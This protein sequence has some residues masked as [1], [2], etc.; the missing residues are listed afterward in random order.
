MIT[1]LHL[2]QAAAT[3]WAVF[4]AGEC[5]EAGRVRLQGAT[6]EEKA[7]A[8]VAFAL[9]VQ[10]ASGPLG[11]VTLEDVHCVRFQRRHGN[12]AVV[13]AR[14]LGASHAGLMAAGLPVTVQKITDCRQVFGLHTNEATLLAANRCTGGLVDNVDAAAAWLHGKFWWATAPHNKK[15]E[16]RNDY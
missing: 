13:L 16:V 6:P 5:V 14:L 10:A 11:A 7:T 9:G 2:D 15:I 3:G 12:P 4:R 8:L 1:T